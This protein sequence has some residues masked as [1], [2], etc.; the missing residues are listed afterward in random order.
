MDKLLAIRI[1]IPLTGL[2]IVA[3]KPMTAS[4]GVGPMDISRFLLVCSSRVLNDNDKREIANDQVGTHDLNI[5]WT[6]GGYWNG[7]SPS[8]TLIG[9]SGGQW[10]LSK[11]CT[12]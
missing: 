6:R 10:R 12:C 3:H 11:P 4:R 9:D 2:K 5:E 1:L 8:G 7:Y